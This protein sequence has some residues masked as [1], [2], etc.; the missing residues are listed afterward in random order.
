M[1]WDITKR[2]SVAFE[3][4]RSHPLGVDEIWTAGNIMLSSL[5]I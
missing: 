3:E 1:F 2:R 4:E 5:R